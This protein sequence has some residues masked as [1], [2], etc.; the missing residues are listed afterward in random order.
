MQSSTAVAL[1]ARNSKPAI[2][3]TAAWSKVCD[4]LDFTAVQG[5]LAA[6]DP[7]FQLLVA[8]RHELLQLQEAVTTNHLS[9]LREL[10]CKL[11]VRQHD[12][13]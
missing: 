1:A 11:K 4:E 6:L 5:T 3:L 8:A 9:V 7:E 13:I 2:S 12:T 10:V